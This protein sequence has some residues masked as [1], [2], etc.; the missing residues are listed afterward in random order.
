[1]RGARRGEADA[2]HPIVEGCDSILFWSCMSWR[3][4]WGSLSVGQLE[5]GIILSLTREPAT[6]DETIISALYR[7]G[8]AAITLA[9]VVCECIIV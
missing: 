3:R 2:P 4:A 8:V 5:R 6:H 9:G 1:M 7:S